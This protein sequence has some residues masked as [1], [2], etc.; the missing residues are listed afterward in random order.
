ML[1]EDR[2]DSIV[3]HLQECEQQTQEVLDKLREFTDLLYTALGKALDAIA[4]KGFSQSPNVKKSDL[5]NGFKSFTFDWRDFRVA[6]IPYLYPAY[7]DGDAKL[8]PPQELLGRIVYFFQ[9]KSDD[10]TGSALGELYVYPTG[11]WFAYG[12]VGTMFER[13]ISE[14]KLWNFVLSLLAQLTFNF[15]SYHRNIKDTMFD[16]TP[17]GI[18]SPIGFSLNKP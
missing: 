4:Q 11:M 2:I 8:N 18:S 6:I 14:E 15:T 3:S 1:G 7:P 16:P 10:T 13:E 9:R 5:A 12:L 17:Q